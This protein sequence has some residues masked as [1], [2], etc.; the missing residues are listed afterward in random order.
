MSIVIAFFLDT[1]G[2]EAFVSGKSTG[3]V[4]NGF[5]D[6]FNDT[7]A[8]DNGI[9]GKNVGNGFVEFFKFFSV[10]NFIRFVASLGS[11]NSVLKIFVDGIL[12]FSIAPRSLE[13][14]VTVTLSL[15]EPLINELGPLPGV[16]AVNDNGSPN[17]SVEIDGVLLPNIAFVNF[18]GLFGDD[19]F[20]HK[21]V[22]ETVVGVPV[23]FNVSLSPP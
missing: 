13:K 8:G 3:V 9:V 12:I 14:C 11:L 16:V 21:T 20:V 1:E 19:M 23:R 22:G 18:F 5:V 7:L 2:V 15:A 6:I 4:T 17:G 10:F